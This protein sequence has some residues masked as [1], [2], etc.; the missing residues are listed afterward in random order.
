MKKLLK[1]ISHLST[2]KIAGLA[3]MLGAMIITSCEDEDGSPLESPDG[4]PEILYVRVTNPESADSLLVRANLGTTIAI[5]GKNLGGIREVWF[6]DREATLNPTWVTNKSV[7]VSVPNLAPLDITDKLYLVDADGNILDHDFEVTIPAP[8]LVSAHNEWPQD[9]E[10]LIIYGDYFFDV[11]GVVPV[12]VEF[13]GGT[14][15][16]GEVVS[17]TELHVQVPETAQ[18]GPVTV[19]TNFGISVSPFH[20][21]DSR[22]IILNFDE[23]AKS[24]NGWRSGLNENGNNPINGNYCV[25]RWDGLE[26]YERNEGSNGGP[27]PLMM[28]YKGWRANLV[29]PTIGTGNF[30]EGLYSQ[31]ALKFE[32]QVVSWYGG[33]LHLCPAAANHGNEDGGQG[34]SNQEVWSNSANRRAYWAPWEENNETFTTNGKWITVVIPMTEFKYHRGG[35]GEMEVAADKFNEDA[36]GSLSTWMIGSAESDPSTPFEFYFD[37]MRIVPIE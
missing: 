34:G 25:V 20:V 2:W 16:Q 15:V 30:A 11:E 33:Y 12:E 23:E 14:Q 6:N 27:S 1:Y 19:T 10:D 31:Y 28:E 8:S 26:P 37:N 17:Q 5:V 13:T 21:W 18:E 7:I 3:L 22:N 4:N 29:D 24:G 35:D 36:W 9:G 32:A